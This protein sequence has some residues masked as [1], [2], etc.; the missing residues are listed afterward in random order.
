MQI[1]LPLDEMSTEEK[2]Q[3]METLWDDLCK[4]A[5]S[6]SSPSWH[7]DILQEREKSIKNGND[8]FVDWEKAKKDIRDT[9]S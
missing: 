5:D 7:K 3:T 1:T 6:L 2:I 9:I 4:K 8:A